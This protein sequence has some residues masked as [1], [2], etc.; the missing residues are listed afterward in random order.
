M[1]RVLLALAQ[2]F[3]EIEAVTSIDILRRAGLNVFIGSL[4]RDLLVKGAHGIIIKADLFL[5]DFNYVAD[6]FVL[7]GGLPGAENLANSELVNNLIIKCIEQGKIVAAICAS[8]AYVLSPLGI[9]KGKSV[10]C[11]PGCKDRLVKDAVYLEDDVVVDGKI[12]TS[13]GVGTALQFA[14][15]IVKELV[16]EQAALKVKNAV[17]VK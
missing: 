17:L 11:Y 2:G 3:E 12:I 15:T 1:L 5:K 6:A 13:A 4:G 9:L 10:T 8:P 14:L 16:G 7:P